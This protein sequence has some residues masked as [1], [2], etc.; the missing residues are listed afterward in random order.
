MASMGQ[1]EKAAVIADTRAPFFVA[2]CAL[3]AFVV[4]GW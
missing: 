2:L 3:C 4:K 1:N